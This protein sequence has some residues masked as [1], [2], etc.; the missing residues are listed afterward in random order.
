VPELL[1]YFAAERAGGFVL[2]A[3]G[4]A[5]IVLA[6]FLW[7]RGGGYKAMLWPLVAI[8]LVEVVVGLGVALRTPAQVEALSRGM[9]QERSATVRAESERMARV[10]RSFA[11]LEVVE[12]A[13]LGI[14]LMLAWL[15]PRP[16]TWSSVGMGLALQAAVLLVFDHFAAERAAA[17]T[18]W[19]Q[20]LA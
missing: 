1:A 10:N 7:R 11:V 16:G 9:L 13:L 6:A 12:V 20:S 3:I 15:L 4:A 19:L 5:A 17:Y 18:R 2:A 8:G 14:G